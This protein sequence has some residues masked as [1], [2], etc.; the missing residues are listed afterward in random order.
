MAVTLVFSADGTF[1]GT[2]DETPSIPGTWKQDR[3]DEYT[4]TSTT[5]ETRNYRYDADTDT[6]Y[7]VSYTD[8]FITRQ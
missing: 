4:V 3:V 1:S 6:L 8:I 5:K 2:L 7:D